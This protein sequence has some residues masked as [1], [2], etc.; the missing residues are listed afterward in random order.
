MATRMG[1]EPTIFGVTGRYVKPLHH[2][3][4]RKPDQRN[5]VNRVYV[6]RF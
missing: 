1:F 5:P 6:F 3:A 2:R 4:T